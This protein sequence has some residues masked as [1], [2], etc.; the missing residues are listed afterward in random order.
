MDARTILV[1]DSTYQWTLEALHLAS[2]IAKTNG[3]VVTLVQL[4]P[5]DHPLHLGQA[6]A[7]RHYTDAE[8]QAMAEY[9]ATLEDY[10][11]EHSSVLFQSV[12]RD[13]AIVSAAEQFH[14]I[15]VF[16]TLPPSRIP[17]WRRLL[18]WNMHRRLK[19]H[20]CT[21]FTLDNT[22]DPLVWPP[23]PVPRHELSPE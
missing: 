17:G 5:V 10:G 11:V 1:C 4:V 18:I 16:A 6:F 19:Q 7:Y 15:I 14:A 8:R 12:N 3:Y 9:Q 23:T 21:L 22:L 13:D 2:A 20:G